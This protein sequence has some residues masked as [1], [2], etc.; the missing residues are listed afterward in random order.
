M[1]ITIICVGKLKEKY[2]KEAA[3]EYQKR[4]QKHCDLNI[5]EIKEV[6]LENES[7]LI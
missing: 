3:S 1:N 7:A 6:G 4:L 2:L 5:F